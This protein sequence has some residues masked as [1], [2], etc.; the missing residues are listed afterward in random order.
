[1]ANPI[2]NIKFLA[3][4]K[5]FSTG[6]QNANRKL[7]G[8]GKKMQS[9]GAG[10]SLALTTPLVGVAT[11]ALKAA[12]DFE[13]LN[14]SLNTV[15]Q[16]NEVAAKAAFKTINDFTAKTPFQ[17]EEVAGAFI[18]LKNL[19]LD[20]SIESLNSYGNT[21]SALGK[22]LDQMVEAVADAAVGEFERLKEFGI[23]AKSEGEN[24]SFTFQGLT[25]TIGKNAQEI[26]QYLKDIGNTSF[27]GAIEKQSQTFYGQLSTLKDNI[28]LLFADFGVIII[29]ALK[30]ILQQIPIIIQNFR[31]LSPTTK[32][33]ILV[34]G[35]VAA[36]IGPLLA[37]AGT[38]LPAIGTGFAILT[39]PIGLVVA[40][41]AAVG[42]VIYKNFG[43]IKKALIDIANYFVDLY[44]ESTVFRLGVELIITTFKNMFAVGKFIFSTLGNIISLVGTSI[45]N[46]F[47]GIGS[48]I[49]AILTGN[50]SELGNIFKKNFADGF[51]NVKEFVSK[52]SDEF[53][54]LNSEITGNIK[55]GI[56]NGFKGRAYKIAGDDVDVSEITDKVAT[57]VAAGLAGGGSG[58]DLTPQTE[59]LNIESAGIVDP[60]TSIQDQLIKSTENVKIAVRETAAE[61]TAFQSVAQDIGL[62][63]G[64]AFESMAGRFV[65]SLGLAKTGFQGF[66]AGL[67]GTITKLISMLL[68]NSIA[69]AIVGATASGAATGPAAIFTTPAFIT[70][71]VSGVVAAFAAIPKFESGGVVN[72]SS[73]YGDKILARVNSGELILNQNQ[74]K[75]VF[76]MMNNRSSQSFIAD[77][78]I[79]G[80]DIIIA[81]KRAEKKLNRKG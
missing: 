77:T 15:F 1:M 67:L 25:T 55:Q 43:P 6:M 9:I 61:L 23:K 50:F 74:Q 39:G 45:K 81:Y 54:A 28:K 76:G 12:A 68:A 60:I 57:G 8:L 7:E 14:V 30:P 40:A 73:F 72:G 46:I 56:E 41:I 80:E 4:L 21:A 59:K 78:R 34:L 31:D 48:A 66:V 24:V 64:D 11:G 70:T 58:P 52:S 49:K 33:F 18:K 32:K 36:A 16:G 44:N 65:E 22:S 47:S 63:V 37:L 10:L 51:G 62:S 13:K 79:Q 26:E 5:S 2:I 53:A 27:A 71:A 35:G 3:D 75:D 38:I 17:L 69:N 20:P 42:F 19:G 29:D